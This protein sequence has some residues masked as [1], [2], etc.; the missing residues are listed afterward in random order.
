V[1]AR[2]RE[3]GDL[4]LAAEGLLGDAAGDRPAR[5]EVGTVFEGLHEIARAEGTG[6]QGRKLIPLR[7]SPR[8]LRN[9]TQSSR[10]STSWTLPR[11]SGL[12]RLVT[13]QK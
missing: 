4:G 3:I 5:L 1:L 9:L 10:A 13:T 6:S 12:L 8:L 2:V 11:R 7:F